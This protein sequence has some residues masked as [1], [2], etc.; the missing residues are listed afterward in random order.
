VY[1][2]KIAIT[3]SRVHQELKM[4]S[5]CEIIRIIMEREVPVRLS[6]LDAP[7]VTLEVKE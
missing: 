6:I 4:K 2:E 1:L 7:A 5:N 3:L